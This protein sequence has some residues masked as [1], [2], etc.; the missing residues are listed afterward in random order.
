MVRPTP[1]RYPP[2]FEVF[3]PAC[4]SNELQHCSRA[5]VINAYDNTIVYADHVL[6]ELIAR[7]RGASDQVDS[8]LL[9][10]SDHGESLGEQG[11]YLHGLPYRFAPETQKHVPMLMWTSQGY[12]LRR[13]LS[14]TCLRSESNAAVSHDNLYHT[15]LG[16]A[17]VRNA[18]YDARLDLLAACLQSVPVNHE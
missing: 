1:R 7:L 15:V 14:T 2:Q 9:Y 10:A 5:E 6:S 4:R 3:K 18:S 12:Q 16:A 11:V 8:V 13:H 17:G